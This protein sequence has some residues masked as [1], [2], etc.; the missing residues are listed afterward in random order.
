MK[1]HQY[2]QSFHLACAGR[3]NPQLSPHIVLLEAG[4]KFDLAKVEFP[5]KKT[6]VEPQRWHRALRVDR[7]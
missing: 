3:S 1:L 7:E 4:A 6:S 2:L 5:S